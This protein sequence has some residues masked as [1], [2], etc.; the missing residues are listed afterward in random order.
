LRRCALQFLAPNVGVMK[1]FMSNFNHFENDPVAKWIEKHQIKFFIVI[2]LVF[3]YI[4]INDSYERNLCENKCMKSGYYSFRFKP[5]GRYSDEACYCL[6][7]EESKIK[8]KIPKGK[9]IGI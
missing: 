1:L 4:F 8:D 6:S 3:F 5:D 7:E 2:G 9:K